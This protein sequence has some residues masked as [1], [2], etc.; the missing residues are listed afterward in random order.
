[1]R[2]R[3]GGHYG[4]LHGGT[5]QQVAHRVEEEQVGR[6]VAVRGVVVREGAADRLDD[7]RAE[8]ARRHLQRAETVQ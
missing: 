1:M 6:A 2:G 8:R 3:H 5:L 4:R 7:A